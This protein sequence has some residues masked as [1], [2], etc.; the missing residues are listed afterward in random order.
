M[1]CEEHLAVEVLQQWQQQHQQ[2]VLRRQAPPASPQPRPDCD[3]A[4]GIPCQPSIEDV[5]LPRVAVTIP[6]QSAEKGSHQRPP[7]SEEDS[8]LSDVQ[9][10]VRQGALGSTGGMSFNGRNGDLAGR[11]ILA[12]TTPGNT[13]NTG[14]PVSGALSS[15]GAPDGANAAAEIVVEN[16]DSGCWRLPEG[17][18]AEGGAVVEAVA[19]RL[20]MFRYGT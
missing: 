7:S 15:Y 20:G 9:P 6:T 1:A 13:G 19:H 11:A 12:A 5:L 14:P 2:Q 4:A 10:A 16:D 3:A 18:V 17:S 8:E